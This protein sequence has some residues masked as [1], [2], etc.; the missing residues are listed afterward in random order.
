MDQQQ[1]IMLMADTAVR[2]IVIEGVRVLVWAPWL[3]GLVW[4]H[5]RF[6]RR[7]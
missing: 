4:L 3:I 2:L 5:A 7:G 6:V 1:A